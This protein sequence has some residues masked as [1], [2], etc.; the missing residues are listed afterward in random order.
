MLADFVLVIVTLRQPY[1]PSLTTFWTPRAH[2]P[3]GGARGRCQISV[4]MWNGRTTDS[5]LFVTLHFVWYT[6]IPS[7]LACT[8]HVRGR[9]P[10]ECKLA[11]LWT[12][13]HWHEE[14]IRETCSKSRGPREE[15]ET[16]WIGHHFFSYDRVCLLWVQSH[17]LHR[18]FTK[19]WL[20][21][22]IS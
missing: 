4:R 3:Q 18:N 22:M 21:I 11:A 20:I 13:L 19:T 6:A 10:E 7:A 5:T 8:T 12:G 16:F 15:N 14:T 9:S 2:C 17:Q 1:R